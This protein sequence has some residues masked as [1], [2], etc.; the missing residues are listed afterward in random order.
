MFTFK[1]FEIA[2]DRTAMKVGTDGVLLGAWATPPLGATDIL[3]IGTGTGVIALML[4]QRF[5]KCQVDG[6]EIDIQSSLQ[7]KENVAST[8][9]RERITIY[10]LSVQSFA[11]E[12]GERRYD[13]VVSNP[14]YFSNSLKSPD[15]KRTTARHNDSLSIEELL[16]SSSRVLK[17]EGRLSVVLPIQEG[18]ELI[19]RSI[20]FGFQTTRVC[21]V[22]PTMLSEKPK[23]L[24]IEL[25]L[26]Q[27]KIERQESRL[28]IEKEKRGDYTEDYIALTKDF[29]LKF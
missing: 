29:Y 13:S 16:I 22:F 11:D 15:N 25:S 18:E 17:L 2:Q 4:A 9:W 26:T 5:E 10:N 7:A 24:L 8:L 6:V 12:I 1:R 20:K 23:R 14:P 28:V 21:S 19:K 3:D 27:N